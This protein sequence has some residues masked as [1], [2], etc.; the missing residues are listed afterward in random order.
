MC[1]GTYVCVLGGRGKVGKV[2]KHSHLFVSR[3][4]TRAVSYCLM[5]MRCCCA[6]SFHSQRINNDINI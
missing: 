6:G 1:S 2:A 3:G 5:Q 4:A